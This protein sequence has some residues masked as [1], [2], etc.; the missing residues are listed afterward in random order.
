MKKVK[1]IPVAIT[2]FATFS[3]NTLAKDQELKKYWDRFYN[4]IKQCV[5][6]NVK[7]QT[8]YK[9]EIEPNDAI[10]LKSYLKALGYENYVVFLKTDKIKEPDLCFIRY[11]LKNMGYNPHYY[12]TAEILVVDTFQRKVDAESLKQKLLNMFN[13]YVDKNNVYILNLNL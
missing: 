13:N 1:L 11:V 2:M 7:S 9:P 3:T 8:L 12:S 4:E 6:E 10:G 5:M